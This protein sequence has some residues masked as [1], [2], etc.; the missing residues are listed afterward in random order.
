MSHMPIDCTPISATTFG[1]KT[2]WLLGKRVATASVQKTGSLLLELGAITR[3]PAHRSSASHMMGEAAIL[4]E[5]TWR[6]QAERSILFGSDSPQREIGKGIADLTGREVR[7]IS[8]TGDIPE[9]LVSLSGGVRIQSFFA[10]HGNPH[11]VIMT[12]NDGWIWVSNGRLVYALE[13]GNSGRPV[14]ARPNQALL[15]T[16]AFFKES[17]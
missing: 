12:H 16:R 13:R 4:M 3:V 15:P 7:G 14:A 17:L 8:V 11:W 1:R 10:H 6:A 5:W 9:L 2:K